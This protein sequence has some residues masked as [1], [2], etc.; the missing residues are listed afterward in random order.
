MFLLRI[1]FLDEALNLE[2]A[3]RSLVAQCYRRLGRVWPAASV[4]VVLGNIV[5]NL[6]LEEDEGAIES[7]DRAFDKVN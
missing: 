5:T 3:G 2:L 4:L 1:F 7:D 6:I